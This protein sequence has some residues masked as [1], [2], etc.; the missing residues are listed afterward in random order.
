[1]K[2][3]AL[4]IRTAGD[5]AL[6]NAIA[7]NFESDEIRRLRME[8]EVLRRNRDELRRHEIEALGREIDAR[9]YGR[10]VLWHIQ[11]AIWRW[12]GMATRLLMKAGERK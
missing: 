4:V 11:A 6:C 9:I 7:G 10:R 3:Q 12:V 1:M 8:N 2:M 5:P